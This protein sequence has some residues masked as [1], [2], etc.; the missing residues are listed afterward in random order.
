[1]PIA[2]NVIHVGIETE[3][4]IV[5]ARQRG[6][7]LAVQLGFSDTDQTLVAT[8]VSEIVRNIVTYAGSGKVLLEIVEGSTGHGIRVQ[9]TDSGPGIGDV[10]MALR[11]GFSTG[12]SLGMGLPGAR[13]LMDEFTIDSAPGSGTTIVMVKWLPQLAGGV[14]P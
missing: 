10:D 8:A 12:N 6:R 9:A 7:E 14:R 1:M 5:T 2:A 13:R 4:D 11:D 3:A